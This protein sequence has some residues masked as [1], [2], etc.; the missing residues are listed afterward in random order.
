[1][2]L[3]PIRSMAAKLALSVVAG[4]LLAVILAKTTGVTLHLVPQQ[5]L[6]LALWQPFTFIPVEMQPLGVIFGALIIFSMGGALEQTWGPKRLFTFAVSTTFAAGLLTVA[7]S[8]LVT[9][10]RPFP[11]TGGTVM[12]S[13]VW[14]AYG[15]SHA[16]APVNFWGAQITGN[17]FALIGIGFVVLNAAFYGWQV[18]VPEV[19][20][21]AI[22]FGYLRLGSPRY[23][24][25]RFQSWRLQKQL[26]GRAKHLK[27][28]AD[29]RNTPSDSDR[30]LH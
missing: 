11:F 9:G 29:D 26:K 4:S 24:W 18:V 15:W 3:P 5:V 2:G 16:H 10:L 25:L 7:L 20:A 8:L 21:I 27:L 30:Y 14:I 17:V 13:I 12:A 19:F 23:V 28:I 6:E 1:M 22:T